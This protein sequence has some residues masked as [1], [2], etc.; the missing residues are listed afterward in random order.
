[1]EM[2][3]DKMLFENLVAIWRVVAHFRPTG[4]MNEVQLQQTAVAFTFLRRIDC[5]IGKYASDCA[6]FYSK[7]AEKLSEERLSEKLCE[8]SGGYP[9]YNFSGYNF[10]EI[11]LSNN[12]IEVVMN[13]YLQ[14]FSKNV[15]DILSGMDFYNNLAVLNRQSRFL[16]DLLNCCENLDF[17]SS[18]VDNEEFVQILI[19]MIGNASSVNGIFLTGTKLS[20]LICGC[21]MAVDVRNKKDDYVTIYDPV[22]GTG[23]LLALAG[24]EAKTFAVHQDNI[25]LYGQEISVFPSAIAKALVMLCGNEYSKVYYGDTLTD[26][27]FH[28]LSF[29]YIVADMPFGINWWIVKDSIER[30]SL[31]INGRFSKGLPNYSDSLFL[32]I[33]HTISKMDAN[34]S[35][36][37]FLTPASALWRGKATSGE[38]R[39]RR[40]LFE[41][42]M[43]ET[44]IALPASDSLAPSNV[45]VFL[46]ILS[47]CKKDSQKNKI[48]LINATSFYKKYKKFS[49]MDDDAINAVVA[50]Y[51]S[52]STS[53]ISKI[54]ENSELGFFEVGFLED[55]KKEGTITISLN[56]DIEQ[57]I[58]DE[59]QPYSKGVISID[60]SS[61]EKGYSLRFDNYFK[62][63]KDKLTSLA[64]E[65]EELLNAIDHIASIKAEVDKIIRSSKNVKNPPLFRVRPLHFAVNIV[66]GTA[67]PTEV[68][69]NGL[70]LLSVPYMRGKSEV[71]ELYAVTVKS[72]CATS[73]DALIVVKGANSGE[74]FK[75]VD[76]IISSSF[77]AVK[78]EN[79]ALIA[80]QYLY[81]LI[82]G[83]EKKLMSLATGATIKSLD[84]KTIRSLN[85]LIPPL[86]EQVK[87]A[88]Y[89]DVVIG[90]IDN[91]IKSI[92]S[93]D[94]IFSQYRQ[95][96]IENAIRGRLKI[97]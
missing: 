6:T 86:E 55:G 71:S 22:C 12:S 42:D 51:K 20:R 74:V 36:V 81:Y 27:H 58:K 41:N 80:P 38:S 39:I 26:D 79:E 90:K 84:V 57:F 25:S 59:I 14:G 88:S 61:V 23:G 91:V 33:E 53:A 44:I 16:V 54:V 45:N 24:E 56:T 47:N 75:G 1:M 68:D 11:L 83:Y 69:K 2:I 48:R 32:F 65:S 85:C 82:K 13:S 35:R 60:Y 93:S 30:E 46:W 95:T 31:D 72:R 66:L 40:W 96:L 34:G 7:N 49:F 21:L 43:V 76:G 8:I 70:P 94:S 19:S 17:S 18:N 28:D 29:K 64:Y 63:E 89:L 9:F 10:K 78:C 5:L 87:I 4:Q 77:A 15:Q 97:F 3:E 62:S 92:H 50:E 37:A 52:N 67:R 73:N